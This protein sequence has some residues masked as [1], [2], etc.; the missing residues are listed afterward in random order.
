[1]II[2]IPVYES[3]NVH[4]SSGSLGEGSS[5]AAGWQLVVVIEART[6]LDHLLLGTLLSVEGLVCTHTVTTEYLPGVP[7]S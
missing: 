6:D 7:A 4:I 5:W 2:L 3:P 1:M